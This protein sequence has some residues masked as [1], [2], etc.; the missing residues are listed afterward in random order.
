MISWNSLQ[1]FIIINSILTSLGWCEHNV[2]F[3]SIPVYFLFVARN[4]FLVHL[5][6]HWSRAKPSVD[7]DIEP[8]PHDRTDYL[9]LCVSTGTEVLTHSMA[10]AMIRP[11]SITAVEPLSFI[12]KTFYLEV[13]FDFFHYWSHRLSHE[14]PWLYRCCHKI[15]HRH[16]HPT[17]L[18]TFH[19]HPVDLFLTNTLPMLF[20]LSLCP[21]GSDAL[22]WH[23]FLVYKSFVEI[24]G[25]TSKIMAPSGSF[26]QFVWLVRFMGIQLFSE[27]HTLH[28]TRNQCNYSKRFSL[29]DRCFGTYRS[30]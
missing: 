15:H 7:N 13:V 16:A 27:E 22:F 17:A 23:R 1:N 25:H 30:F 10:S 28:H 18:R 9:Y 8:T 2:A 24:S 4:L 3:Y 26:P 6:A 12:V 14:I 29:W 21:F 5:I 11:S 19:H 20:A